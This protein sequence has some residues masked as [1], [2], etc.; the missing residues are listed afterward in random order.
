MTTLIGA[1][2]EYANSPKNET[3]DTSYIRIF[4]LCMGVELGLS[5]YKKDTE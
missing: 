3:Y 2:H 5:L 1:F 4:T